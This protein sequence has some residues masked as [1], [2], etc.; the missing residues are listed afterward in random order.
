MCVSSSPVGLAIQVDRLAV[1]RCRTARSRLDSRSV[2]SMILIAVSW[3]PWRPGRCQMSPFPLSA[4]RPSQ[5][6][7]AVGGRVGRVE[8][9][10]RACA[11]AS[12]AVPCRRASRLSPRAQPLGGLQ[13]LEHLPQWPHLLDHRRQ[14]GHGARLGQGLEGA[15]GGQDLL[16]RRGDPPAGD[17]ATSGCTA[18]DREEAD[19]GAGREGEAGLDGQ[20][21]DDRAD[22]LPVRLD[23]GGVLLAGVADGPELDGRGL[24]QRCASRAVPGWRAGSRGSPGSPAERSRCR[25]TTRAAST[26]SAADR[27]AD[28]AS[29]SRPVSALGQA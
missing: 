12:G 26:S 16:R 21:R 22:D 11:A 19:H 24:A 18:A 13:P 25:S 9:D 2:G 29:R 5:S 6:A 10:R 27:Q 15:E 17:R 7:P 28:A 14:P 20:V 1:A 4:T 3:C 8:R 23:V